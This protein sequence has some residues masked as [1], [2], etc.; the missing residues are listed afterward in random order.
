MQL[1]LRDGCTKLTAGQ[2]RACH[3]KLIDGQAVKT[4]IRS[5]SVRDILVALVP[6]TACQC[7]N[8]IQ[9]LGLE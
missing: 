7:I 8:K 6:D 9:S 1:M 3:C 5:Q 2:S 4:K